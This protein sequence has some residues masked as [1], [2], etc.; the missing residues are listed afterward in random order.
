MNKRRHLG[1]VYTAYP[2]KDMGNAMGTTVFKFIMSFFSCVIWGVVYFVMVGVI[3]FVRGNVRTEIDATAPV[4]DSIM[5]PIGISVYAVGCVLVVIGAFQ[6]KIG[7]KNN[8][9]DKDKK[10]AV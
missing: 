7:E 3:H 2:A 1:N 6:S 10:V 4:M 8:A 5:T 9:L